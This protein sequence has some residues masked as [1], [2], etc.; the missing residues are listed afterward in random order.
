MRA[1]PITVVVADDHPVFRLGIKRALSVHPTL[2]LVGEAANGNAAL[3]LIQVSLP[4][5]ALLDVRM[6]G[7]DGLSI[8]RTLRAAGAPT[9]VVLISAFADAAGAHE[10]LAA[11]AH[12]YLGKDAEDEEI[13]AAVTAAAKGTTSVGALLHGA[14][15]EQIRERAA[16]Q[17]PPLSPREREVLVRIARGQR[18][19]QIGREMHLSETTVKTY[20]ARAYEKLGVTDRASAAAEAVRRGLLSCFPI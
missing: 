1:D 7:P 10:A 4:D 5:V 6:P 15:L 13:A 19:S 16:P 2:E 9:H 12:R 11:G 3:S 14:V 8:V 17:A 20:L 18:R